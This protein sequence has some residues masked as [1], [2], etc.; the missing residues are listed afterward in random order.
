MKYISWKKRTKSRKPV[1]REQQ[2]AE[3]RLVSDVLTMAQLKTFVAEYRIC[4]FTF[5]SLEALRKLE[6]LLREIFVTQQA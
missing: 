2:F 6:V 3:D 4:N 1:R 5:S